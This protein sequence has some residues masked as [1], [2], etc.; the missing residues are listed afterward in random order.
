MRD[1]RTILDGAEP[2]REKWVRTACKVTARTS[3]GRRGHQNTEI[4]E[5]EGYSNNA[6]KECSINGANKQMGREMR[7]IKKLKETIRMRGVVWK[8]RRSS[9]SEDKGWKKSSKQNHNACLHWWFANSCTRWKK[10]KVKD[11]CAAI[12]NDKN[13]KTIESSFSGIANISLWTP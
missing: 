8:Q 11:R 5:R 7:T 2:S 6:A 3:D 4:F 1:R 13:W 9:W 10:T 12:D